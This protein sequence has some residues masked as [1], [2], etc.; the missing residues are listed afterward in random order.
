[1]QHTQCDWYLLPQ[2]SKLMENFVNCLNN[3]LTLLSKL[4]KLSV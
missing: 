2:E 4:S 3:P 1:M